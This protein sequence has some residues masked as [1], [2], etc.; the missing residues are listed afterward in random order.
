[1]KYIVNLAKFTL[2]AYFFCLGNAYAYLDPGTGSII[3]QAI[4]ASIAAVSAAGTFYWRK[5]KT[6]IKSLF[7]KK[8]KVDNSER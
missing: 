4:I 2:C 3:L 6:K 5:I 7:T 8:N 1:M